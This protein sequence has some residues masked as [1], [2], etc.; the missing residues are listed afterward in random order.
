[1]TE[2]LDSTRANDGDIHATKEVFSYERTDTIYER[3]ATLEANI[4]RIRRESLTRQAI[5]PPATYDEPTEGL[6][7]LLASPDEKPLDN[8]IRTL[9]TKVPEV[10]EAVERFGLNELTLMQYDD[11]TE[12]QKKHFIVAFQK[13]YNLILDRST[14]SRKV[15]GNIQPEGEARMP[16][17]S[18]QPLLEI[19]QYGRYLE[20]LLS[21]IDETGIPAKVTEDLQQFVT[22][23]DALK[24]V[25]N[26]VD[27]RQY[28][29]GFKVSKNGQKEPTRYDA[30]MG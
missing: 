20:A 17:G 23:S 1:M 5:R 6:H 28:Q 11:M 27:Y 19:I 2:V 30:R 9:G 16:Q 24:P 8:V 13:F 26:R 10:R 18:D 29:L 14:G 25:L 3:P 22:N 15:E 12:L 7:D 21:A 4:E